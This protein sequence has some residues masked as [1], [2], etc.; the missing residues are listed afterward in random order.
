MSDNDEQKGRKVAAAAKGLNWLTL[1]IL[2]ASFVA[3]LVH[4]HPG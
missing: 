4:K 1:A 2:A 3:W